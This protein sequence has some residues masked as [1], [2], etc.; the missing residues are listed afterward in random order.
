MCIRDRSSVYEQILAICQLE[1]EPQDLQVFHIENLT[2]SSPQ[3]STQLISDSPAICDDRA[4]TEYIKGE[5]QCLKFIIQDLTFLQPSNIS[6]HFKNI[7]TKDKEPMQI[8]ETHSEPNPRKINLPTCIHQD[9]C[10]NLPTQ[11]VEPVLG[12]TPTKIC[13]AEQ[14]PELTVEELLQLS[15]IHI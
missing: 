3:I 4:F 7:S 13:Q 1:Q 5:E 2:F 10:Q 9:Q 8:S 15:L 6:P 14:D 11:T 12:F